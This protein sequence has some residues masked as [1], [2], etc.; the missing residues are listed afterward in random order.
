MSEVKTVKSAMTEL[1]PDREAKLIKEI[2]ILRQEGDKLRDGIARLNVLVKV[3]KNKCTVL[4]HKL[5]AKNLQVQGLKEI[6]EL[7]NDQAVM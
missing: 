5:E 1:T 7:S 3:W 4:T 6:I 2:D